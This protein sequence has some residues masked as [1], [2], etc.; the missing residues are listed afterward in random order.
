MF[1]S[2]KILEKGPNLSTKFPKSQLFHAKP[3]FKPKVLKS[4]GQA[5]YISLQNPNL[6]TDPGY[7]LQAYFSDFWCNIMDS[8]PYR[9]KKKK[10][11]PGF[12]PPKAEFQGPKGAKNA[13]TPALVRWQKPE[14]S[15]QYSELLTKLVGRELE[16]MVC[17]YQI[18]WR[19]KIWNCE[20]C[21]IPEHLTCIKKWKES[22]GNRWNCPACN[23]EYTTEPKYTC[24][25]GKTEEPI[26]HPM[27]PPH[28]C[29]EVCGR[30][31]GNDCP[32]LC[33]QQCH[34]GACPPCTSMAPPQTC[35]CGKKTYQPMCKDKH[36]GQSC[37]EICGKMLNCSSHYCQN[38]CHEGPCQKCLVVITQ[39]CY[40]GKESV[41]IDCGMSAVC[42]N[43]CNKTLSCGKH[44][45]DRICHIGSCGVC[46]LSPNL[47]SRCP[48]GKN[49]LDMILLN[50]RT[51]CCDPIPSCYGVCDKVLPCGHKCKAVCHNGSCPPCKATQS[52]TC[53]CTRT[54]Q[55]VKC[56]DLT[57][58]VLCNKL[59]TTKKSCKRHKCNQQCC[60]GLDDP[61]S[62]EHRCLET[63]GKILNCSIHTCLG[64][65]HIGNCEPCKV[66]TRVR[67]F[68]PCGRSYKDPPI[69]CGTK[70]MEIGCVFKC[71]KGLP[72]GHN[73]LSTCHSGECPSCSQLTEKPCKCGKMFLPIGC[74]ILTVSCGKICGKV[75]SCE[76]I[77]V[78]KCHNE[79]CE[80]YIKPHLCKKKRDRC[81]HTCLANCHY[82]NPCPLEPC[83]V[84]VS[85][86][87]PCGSQSI[88]AACG[89][90]KALECDDGCLKIKRDKAL[91]TGEKELYS[92][93]LVEFAKGNMEFISK[94][95]AKLAT[96]IAKKDKVTFLPPMKE[97][98]RWLCH[99]LATHHYKLDTQSLDKEPY[100]S[101]YIYLTDAARVP[102]PVLSEFVSL[103]NQGIE[104]EFEKKE[105]MASLLFYQLS[106]S[107]T[108]DDLNDI[109]QK[110]SGDF[111][112]KWENDHSAYA[113]FF[114]I[115]KCSE[116]KKILERTPGQY[117]VVKMTMN[118]PAEDTTGFKKRFRNTKKA[119]EVLSFDDEKEE[120]NIVEIKTQEKPEFVKKVEKIV[121]EKKGSIFQELNEED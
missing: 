22:S 25:C 64:H 17:M 28:S 84:H 81:S 80:K 53:R 14:G 100:R 26:P 77:C 62:D 55:D 101:V 95:E 40:C 74:G 68:C 19:G 59:C 34:P 57:K 75:L 67:I 117:S 33:P 15:E 56:Q 54:I 13:K 106:S 11:P 107:V 120:K 113:H 20:Q 7:F 121:E 94:V 88:I 110:Y 89:E 21:R 49:S 10:K 93:E 32:H 3:I 31:R 30:S 36:I 78:E 98:Q 69:R 52:I 66:I 48:C 12:K 58:Q 86:F 37:E 118:T 70:D 27:Y 41:T 72:C 51:S 46:K 24:F 39:D 79:E 42:Q 97:K 18:G 115:H 92:E 96:I 43:R 29:G 91:G 38:R 6:P 114:S 112:I 102:Q 108:T 61:Y 82:P 23:F 116:A 119:K 71:G 4:S 76:H 8:K 44:F 73:C 105:I 111:Y 1:I 85:V 9:F 16:C 35:Y 99:E 104:T 90:G 50:P 65:C 83:Q 109:L 2:V 5:P 87:C 103:V 63:C 47:V 45:C 60:S